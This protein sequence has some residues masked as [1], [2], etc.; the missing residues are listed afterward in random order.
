MNSTN[1]AKLWGYSLQDC[2][3]EEPGAGDGGE[4]DEDGVEEM[5]AFEGVGEADGVGKVLEGD[6]DSE[7]H[8]HDGGARGAALRQGLRGRGDDE[9]VDGE[10]VVELGRDAVEELGREQDGRYPQAVLALGPVHPVARR[11]QGQ[12]SRPEL[13]LRARVALQQQHR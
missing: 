12:N 5:F 10:W 8:G 1:C 11:L 9:K 3:A 13:L 7:R 2:E 6:V 4:G